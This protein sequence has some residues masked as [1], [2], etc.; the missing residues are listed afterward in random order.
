MVRVHG[1]L[2]IEATVVFKIVKLLLAVLY[3][4]L[5][6]DLYRVIWNIFVAAFIPLKLIT[7]YG[8]VEKT[9]WANA[10]FCAYWILERV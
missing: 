6:G 9:C 2:K 10:D 3:L 5:V 1:K 8:H 4:F 7:R